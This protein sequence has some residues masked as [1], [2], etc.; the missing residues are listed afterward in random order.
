MKKVDHKVVREAIANR[1]KCSTDIVSF[2]IFCCELNRETRE[3][4]PE[5]YIRYLVHA[6]FLSICKKD[7]DLL[8]EVKELRRLLYRMNDKIS[9]MSAQLIDACG[10]QVFKSRPLE[11]M[12][13]TKE[14]K[15]LNETLQEV[16]KSQQWPNGKDRA[17]NDKF[18][19][20]CRYE[21]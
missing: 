19:N 16:Q 7:N 5:N 14:Y 11:R 1:L 6:V 8:K 20:V 15:L 2:R 3:K 12:L 10:G 18:I 4:F 13:S 21:D 17:G 9:K